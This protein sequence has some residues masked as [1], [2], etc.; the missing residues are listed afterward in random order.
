MSISSDGLP[1]KI[2]DIEMSGKACP[3]RVGR[4]PRKMWKA[5]EKRH[6]TDLDDD[7]LGFDILVPGEYD[8]E[9]RYAAR[10]QGLDRSEAVVDCSKRGAGAKHHRR[11]PQRDDIDIDD[12]ARQR[13]Q[14]PAGSLDD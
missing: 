7:A 11:A 2:A 12:F 14:Q 6:T 5:A 4:Q 13:H 9:N 3:Q 8:T 1:Y 10:A